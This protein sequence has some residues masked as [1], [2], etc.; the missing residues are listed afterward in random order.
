MAYAI[1]PRGKIVRTEALRWTFFS[2]FRPYSWFYC[3]YWLLILLVFSYL[4][5]TF[6][7]I[8]N[9]SMSVSS[10]VLRLLHTSR[11]ASLSLFTLLCFLVVVCLVCV[12]VSVARTS[13]SHLHGHTHTHTQ[14]HFPSV[15][16]DYLVAP[17][18]R[19]LN[20]SHWWHR[21]RSVEP[22]NNKARNRETVIKSDKF[23]LRVVINN[24]R[25]VTL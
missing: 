24:I 23:K 9:I 16:S 10:C 17:E 20:L 3:S 1:L 18:T 25:Y 21:R 2:C 12:T 7:N 8:C 14:T 5:S 22:E 19:P 4:W 6:I 15:V 13:P 11:V